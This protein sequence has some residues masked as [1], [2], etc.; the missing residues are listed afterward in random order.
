MKLSPESG[1]YWPQINVLHLTVISTFE[2]IFAKQKGT[3]LARPTKVEGNWFCKDASRKVSILLQL[4]QMLISSAAVSN[5]T[6]II[7]LEHQHHSL[8]HHDQHHLFSDDRYVFQVALENGMEEEQVKKII[9]KILKVIILMIINFEQSYPLVVFCRK[10]L[11]F[12]LH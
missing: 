6:P 9:M 1:E 8:Q 11:F 2:R 4:W 7:T 12:T 3:V 10:C 5:L